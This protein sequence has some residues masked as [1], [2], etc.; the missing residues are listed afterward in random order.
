MLS[1]VEC[2]ARM[3]WLDEA[4][5]DECRTV[6]DTATAVAAWVMPVDAL[7]WP[8]REALASHPDGSECAV[9]PGEWEYVVEVWRD[10]ALLVGVF[11]AST[12]EDDDEHAKCIAMGQAILSTAQ[13]GGDG[14]EPRTAAAFIVGK[15]RVARRSRARHG[16]GGVR[17]PRNRGSDET[18]T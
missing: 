10:D 16:D 11:L 8:A 7:P 12:H 13:P 3:A 5:H 17:W 1:C 9:H 15:R 14:F 2:D 4:M 18:S 6:R